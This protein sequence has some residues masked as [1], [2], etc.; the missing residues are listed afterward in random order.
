[1]K[2]KKH[3]GMSIKI[4]TAVYFVVAILVMT[5]VIAGVGYNFYKT[6]VMDSYTKY[7]TTVL[8]YAH[9]VAEKYSFGEMID[10]REMPEEYET[11]RSELNKIKES[12]DVDY[13]YAVYFDDI[14]D[15]N[16]LTYAINTKTAEELSN[17]GTYTYLGTP[18]EEGSFEDDILLVLQDAVITRKT[19]VGILQGY[20]EGYGYM[21]NGYKVIFNSAGNSEGLICAEI[22]VDNIQEKLDNYI[23]NITIFFFVFTII[24]IAVFVGFAEHFFS[25][26]VAKLTNYVGDFIKKIGDQDAIEKSVQDL[27]MVEVRSANEI[28]KLYSAISKLESDMTDQYREIRRYSE[29]LLKMQDGLIILIADMVENRDSN[30]GDHIQKTAAYVK[31]ILD[32]LKRKGYYSEQLTPKYMEYVVKSA[33]LHDTGKIKI[34]D[35]ILNKP[36]RFT[37]EEFEIMKKHTVY[38]KE[39]I[40]KAISTVEGEGYLTEASNMAAYHHERWDGKGYPEGLKEEEIPLSARIMAVADVF[41]ALASERVYKP[42]FTKEKSLELILEGKGTQF[43]PKCVEVFLEAGPEID[44]V[45]EKYRT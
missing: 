36:G 2:E 12:S 11:M 41:D 17:G 6:N 34:P 35:S 28:G 23:R 45:L 10:A 19:D 20:S 30:T 4:T 43:D 8:E 1:M 21:F 31:I 26:P 27:K 25:Y 5:F 39:I 9:S 14:N 15:V 37:P 7:V 22:N 16:S 44:A 13:M 33:P 18:C 24:M 3:N 42:A 38:G 29:N 32:G 40:E